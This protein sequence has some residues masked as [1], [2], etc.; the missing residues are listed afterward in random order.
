M[1]KASGKT[2]HVT[3]LV[4]FDGSTS[5][6]C[7]PASSSTGPFYCPADQKVYFDLGFMDELTAKFGASGG[8]FAMAYVVSHEFGHHVQDELGINQSVQD[9]MQA[10]PARQNDLSVRMELQADCLAGVWAHS[11]VAELEPGDIDEALN[12]AASVGDDRIQTKT[13]GRIDPEIVDA[14][15]GCR[16]DPVVHDRLPGWRRQQVRHV[17]RRLTRPVAGSLRWA[18]QSAPCGGVA[19][20]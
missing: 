5:S 13:Q 12:A 19:Q 3:K 18:I 8:D 20:W 15:L 1:F 10:D 2:Y 9:Q 7:G 4:L 6:S 16:T 14:R 17:Q 11:A